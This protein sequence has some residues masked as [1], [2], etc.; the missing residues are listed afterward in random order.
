M[1]KFGR[2]LQQ[3]STAS[4]A[5]T[6]GGPSAAYWTS[7]TNGPSSSESW[8]PIGAWQAHIDSNYLGIIAPYSDLGAGLVDAGVNL[9]V[10]TWNWMDEGPG[11]IQRAKDLGLKVFATG[12]D[13]AYLQSN[14]SHASTIVGWQTGDEMDMFR[15]N[16]GAPFGPNSPTTIHNAYVSNKAADS[17]RPQHINWGKPMG[18]WYYTASGGYDTGSQD[19][20]LT[21]YQQ[22]CDATSVDYYWWTDPY[23]NKPNAFGY[24]EAVDWQR[25]YARMDDPHKPIWMFVENSRPWN[26]T[27]SPAITP[28]QME[29]ATWNSIVH[30]ARGIIYFIHDFNPD[31]GTAERGVWS[32]AYY[33][34][35]TG[36]AIIAR[37][38]VVNARL[39]SLASV[40]NS[41]ELG[42]I[43]ASTG[44]ESPSAFVTVSSTGSIPIDMMVRQHGGQT[45]VFAQASGNDTHIGSGNTTATFTWAAGG[46]RTLAVRDESRS[47]TQTNGVWS[48]TFTPYQLHIYVF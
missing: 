17:T 11:Y 12:P 31:N 25:R 18:G 40:I 32:Q 4:Q 9:V 36:D 45:Y 28:A 1:S 15:V 10:G 26:D 27:T 2:R 20:D 44:R 19:G 43:S 13:T 8:F 29:A 39:Q 41:P 6:P 24:G 48:D 22:A 34:R 5:V 42:A 16:D 33:D 3:S 35:T 37:M 47:V 30:G 21:L 23:E 14:P 38:K 7:W 46:S